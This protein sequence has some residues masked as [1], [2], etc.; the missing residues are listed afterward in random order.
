MWS[1]RLP[2]FEFQLAPVWPPLCLLV[3]NWLPMAFGSVSV[4]GNGC[5]FWH[6]K[7]GAVAAWANLCPFCTARPRRDRTAWRR[8]PSYAASIGLRSPSLLSCRSCSP[9]SRARCR[10]SFFAQ[11]AAGG[12]A[13]ADNIPRFRTS[14]TSELMTCALAAERVIANQPRGNWHARNPSAQAPPYHGRKKGE[15]FKHPP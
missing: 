6:R 11:S 15:S 14:R 9:P 2:P 5:Q 4:H 8:F 3:V 10:N 1:F 12:G 7:M 13:L